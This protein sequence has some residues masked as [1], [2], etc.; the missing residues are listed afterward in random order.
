MLA[1]TA[2]LQFIY[3]RVASNSTFFPSAISSIILTLNFSLD[4]KSES[5]NREI[6]F[7]LRRSKYSWKSAGFKTEY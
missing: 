7:T 6:L 2:T 4:T 1:E 5:L 3:I